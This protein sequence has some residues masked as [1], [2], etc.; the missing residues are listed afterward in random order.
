M[1]EQVV[2]PDYREFRDQPV[3]MAQGVPPVGIPTGMALMTP[4]RTSTV[5]PSSTHSTA[6]GYKATKGWMA[7]PVPKG[8]RVFKV[9]KATKGSQVF[10]EPMGP[11]VRRGYKGSRD[12]RGLA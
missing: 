12:L 10:Q 2:P 4:P 9:P 5:T 8:L 3:L 11:Q 6:R 1:V 7:L